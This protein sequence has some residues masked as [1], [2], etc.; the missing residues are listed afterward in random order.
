MPDA[1]LALAFPQL[2][3]LSLGGEDGKGCNRRVSLDWRDS[4]RDAKQ[5]R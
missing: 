5:C 1:S 4:N 3:G 2:A